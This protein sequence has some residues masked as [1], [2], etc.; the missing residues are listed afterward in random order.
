MTQNFYCSSVRPI[1]LFWVMFLWSIPICAF[2][3]REE[4][5][6]TLIHRL[7]QALSCCSH[8]P[9][10]CCC[11]MLFPFYFSEC[12]GISLHTIKVHQDCT[13]RHLS[14]FL[15]TC[16]WQVVTQSLNDNHTSTYTLIEWHKL[17][18][19]GL[20]HFT[21]FFHVPLP[22]IGSLVLNEGAFPNTGLPVLELYP[23][24]R[25]KQFQSDVTRRKKLL[26]N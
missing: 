14:T 23:L 8:T 26:H 4:A 16:L 18:A 10:N 20:Y 17:L 12:F 15:L 13:N 9:F 1:L 7:D 11:E 2:T 22:S 25:M 19:L 3:V 6:Q 5:V 24:S 21:R